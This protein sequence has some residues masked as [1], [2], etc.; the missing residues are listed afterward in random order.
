MT[1]MSVWLELATPLLTLLLGSFLFYEA[2]KRREM[3]AAK[4][5]EAENITAYASE[6]K[7]LYEKKEEK[8]NELNG[9]VDRLY[10][11][12]DALRTEIR[13]LKDENAGLRMENMKL[14]YHRCDVK[15]CGKRLPPSEVMN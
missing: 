4:K 7:E 8:V 12:I 13:R 11:Q 1:D 6:W 14:N 3:A 2:K 5:A 9:K 10:E 15:G